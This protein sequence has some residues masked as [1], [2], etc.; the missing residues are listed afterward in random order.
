[1]ELNEIQNST[2]IS[3]NNYDMTLIIKVINNHFDYITHKM[4]SVK[5]FRLVFDEDDVTDWCNDYLRAGAID[6]VMSKIVEYDPNRGSFDN[7]II[8]I[9]KNYINMKYWNIR[10]DVD[11]RDMVLK[12]YYREKK[13]MSILD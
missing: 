6:W 10:K 5:M 3:V 9:L 4:S 12:P 1:M 2:R 11:F 8:I 13:L 7:Y